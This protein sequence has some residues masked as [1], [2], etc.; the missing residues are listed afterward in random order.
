[1]GVVQ[2][3]PP[4]ATP[5][6]QKTQP[7]TA[8]PTA[9]VE[10]TPTEEVT[11]EPTPSP[12]PA[13]PAT[14]STGDTVTVTQNGEDWATITVTEVKQAASCK[15]SYGYV[16]KPQVT[17]N[18]FIS[19]KE[20]TWLSSTV[21]TTTRFDWDVFCDGVAVNNFSLVIYGPKPALSSGTLPT[22]RTATGYMV[23]EVPKAGEVRM[24]NKGNIFNDAPVFE[25]IIRAA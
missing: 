16:E 14:D 11:L 23:Y 10:V 17:G 1:V 25:V 13:G 24:S 22:G 21:S 6:G 3:V 9:I 4:E 20:R 5:A 18:V 19:A 7:A 12:T 8:V 2:T 15:S